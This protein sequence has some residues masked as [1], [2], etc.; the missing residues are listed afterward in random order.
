MIGMQVVILSNV[1]TVRPAGASNVVFDP[2]ALLC[3]WEW[4]EFCGM[5]GLAFCRRVWDRTLNNGRHVDWFL[6]AS[7]YGQRYD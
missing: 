5:I 4:I 3:L 1:E 6:D 7:C 2:I